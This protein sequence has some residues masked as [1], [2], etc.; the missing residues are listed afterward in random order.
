MNPPTII[1]AAQRL[2]RAAFS[3]G[4]VL[5]LSYLIPH[6]FGQPRSSTAPPDDAAAQWVW[7]N[8]RPQGNFLHGV[9]FIETTARLSG[10]PTAVIPGRFRPVEL[11][12]RFLAFHLLIQP[13][14]QLSAAME[15]FSG[16]PMR[17]T[18]VS[19]RPVEQPVA[20]SAFL[21]LM[22][23]MAPLSATTARSSEQ[24]TPERPG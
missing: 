6:A 3:L 23:I 5:L 9:S 17:G 18:S 1:T 22:P 20:F 4:L 12:T 15:L 11:P 24:M 8:P 21:L 19:P 16:R 14:E 7:Q 2:P 13:P 10:R